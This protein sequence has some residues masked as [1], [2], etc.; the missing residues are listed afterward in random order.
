MGVFFKPLEAEFGWSR[1]VTS[2][3]YIAFTAC[4]GISAMIMGRVLDRYGF[5]L[6]L[7]LAALLTGGAIASLSLIQDVNQFRALMVIA[8]LGVGGCF[9]GPTTVAQQ[10]FGKRQG[11]VLGII[12]SGFGIGSMIFAPLL[13]H[14]I[15][16]QGWRTAYLILG[17]YIIVSLLISN[18]AIG[19]GPDGAETAPADPS[20]KQ[21]PT[22]PQGWTLRQALRT[23]Q[24]VFIFIAFSMGSIGLMM[25]SVHLVPY[26]VDSGI[27]AAS[28]AAA[29][30][31]MGGVSIPI[32]LGIG[33]IQ[34]KIG[35]RRLFIAGHIGMAVAVAVVLRLDS[36]QILYA[37]V[38]IFGLAN[39]IL[40]PALPGLL[41]EYFGM[42]SLG[43]IIGACMAGS[44][45]TGGILG[46]LVGGAS[47]DATHS[48]LTALIVALA[49]LV[50][51][52]ILLLVA[53]HPPATTEET[54][55]S[56]G[57]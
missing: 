52:I 7:L 10:W 6:V 25:L 15:Y 42:A 51:A 47:Y 57:D 48:Y 11:H 23:R 27:S 36:I 3:G 32:R 26:A 24:Y 8:G 45:I 22:A 49:L 37:Y 1:T 33:F 30:G 14:W 9:V 29:L 55:S 54:E 2:S 4:Y 39:A 56:G 20:N 12:T 35:W 34:Q 21:A 41:G 16:S 13:N 19:R 38:I 43:T 17:G 40:A 18:L 28:A 53:K 44:L 46:P 5:R 50:I 31:L